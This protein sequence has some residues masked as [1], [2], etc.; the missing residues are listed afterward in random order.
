MSV[1]LRLKI[2][3]S[4]LLL[5][6]ACH[7]FLFA[8]EIRFIGAS[9]RNPVGTGEQFTIT[10]SINANASSF[11]APSFKDFNVL[12][13]PNQSTSMQIMNGS[14]SQSVDITYY[15]QARTEGTFRIEPAT[16]IVNNTRIKSNTLSITVVK[17]QGKAQSQQQ[18]D[19]S[20]AD[21]GVSSQNVFLK[22]SVDKSNLYRGEA[23]VA[24]Y[25][26]YTRV[27]VINYTID[28]LPAFN[29]FW[30]QELKMPEQLELRNE[31]LIQNG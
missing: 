27:N 8:E 17:G 26:L 12:S 28:K 18:D 20:G 9:N 16:I 19:G 22:V 2:I 11:E 21:A 5:L 1:S 25:K 15:L 6:S 29:G 24:T 23:L 31:I 14:M 30:S 4:S 7:S 3:L 13:G 10:Y